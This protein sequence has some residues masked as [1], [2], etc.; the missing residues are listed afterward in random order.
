LGIRERDLPR[1]LDS[2]PVAK[3]IRARP[4]QVLRITRKSPTAGETIYYRMVSEE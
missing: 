4:G 3:I 1:I 2:D